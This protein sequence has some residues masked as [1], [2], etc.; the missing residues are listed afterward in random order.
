MGSRVLAGKNG[1]VDLSN[2]KFWLSGDLG[3]DWGTKGQADWLVVTFEPKAT[4]EQKD[5][6]M[7]ILTK[8][9]PVKWNSVQMDT[10]DITWRISPDGKTAYAKLANDK[11][12]VKLTRFGG[13][14][15]TSQRRQAKVETLKHTT[16]PT[17][18][19][20]FLFLAGKIWK[21]TRDVSTRFQGIQ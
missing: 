17:A 14:N 2:M 13:V 12:E 6:L 7:P 21:V 16:L 19:L 4:K 18:R 10:S 3:S 1:D 5:A 20:R 11:F 15:Q 9:Y 8:I